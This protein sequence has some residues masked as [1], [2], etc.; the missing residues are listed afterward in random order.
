[1]CGIAGIVRPEGQQ[2]EVATLMRMAASIRHRGPDGY[3]WLRD[4]STGLA[5]VRLSIVDVAGGAQPMLNEDHTVA[6]VYNGEIYNHA[7]LRAQLRERGHRFCSRCD[8]EVLVHGYE[9]WGAGLVEH[10]NGQFAFAVYDRR[11]GSV[12]LAR[13]RFGIRPLY[14]AIHQGTL[15][16][17]SEIKALLASD[18]VDATPSLEGLDEVFTFWAARAPRTTFSGIYSIR[19]GHVARWRNG[20]LIER[21]FYEI[22]Y[23]TTRSEPADSVARLDGLLRDSVR[24]RMRADV[25]VGAYLSG[26]LDSTVTSTLAAGE[27]PHALRTFSVTFHDP[28]LDESVYQVAVADELGSRHAVQRIDTAEIASVFPDVIAHT[29]TPLVRTA[30]APL[31]LLSRLTREAGIKVVLT[32]EGAD[33]LFLGYDLFKETSLRRFCGRQPESARRRQL[34]NRLYPYLRSGARGGDMFARF[35]MSAG[36]E[37][38]PLFSHLPRFLLTA[39][40]KNFYSAETRAALTG[41]DAMEELRGSLP[42]AF[43]TWSTLHRAAWLEMTTLLQSY[44]LSSQGDRMALAHGVEGRFPFLDHRLFEFAAALPERSKLRTLHEKD[45]LKRWAKGVIPDIVRQRTKQPYRAPDAPPFFAGGAPEYVRET[46][47]VDAVRQ[48]GIFDPEAVQG[49]V[50]R[51]HS[52][53]ALGHWENQALVAILST[54]LWHH[55]L[56][57]RFAVPEGLDPNHADV[58][59]DMMTN[60]AGAA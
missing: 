19:P 8:T 59:L 35:F 60:A 3:G 6:V 54:Q 32:G 7:E 57:S 4:G 15:H 18:E 1:M 26:G 30:P 41:F 36:P 38:D 42:A 25:P 10:L 48:A 9:E 46:L 55:L 33:E 2:V 43:P 17:A 5:H 16:F 50:R 14:Y 31:F 52:G 20:A 53:A 23:P 45:I 39:R 49:L 58:Q 12:L 44:L 22:D 29:E 13:D 24:L 47:S 11:N 51:C 40:I 28:A 21:P 34:F 37:S 27:S 56:G